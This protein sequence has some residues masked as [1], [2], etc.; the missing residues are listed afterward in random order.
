[1]GRG[2]QFHEEKKVCSSLEAPLEKGCKRKR[3]LISSHPAQHYGGSR[4]YS[5]HE[6]D[7]GGGG[8]RT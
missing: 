7:S 2:N 8:S 3:S 6:F 1:M 5:S 4:E